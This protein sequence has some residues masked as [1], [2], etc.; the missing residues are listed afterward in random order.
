MQ[1]GFNFA[2]PETVDL[3]LVAAE[4]NTNY[5]AHVALSMTL[6]P[7]LLARAAQG[8]PTMLGFTTSGLAMTP[9]MRCP[10]YSASKA[11][12]HAWILCLREQVR[13]LPSGLKVVELLPPAVQTELHDERHQPDLK[14]GRS[15]GMPL[16][17]FTEGAWEGLVKGWEQIPVGFA[18]VPFKEGGF[19][20]ARQV[21]FRGMNG[22]GK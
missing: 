17:E 18:G 10:N 15:M 3:D 2:K 21:A 9:L 19:E 14:D 4:L 22:L 11:A 8:S 6:L 5:T 1:R 20:V 12:L 13:G 16:G 7:H